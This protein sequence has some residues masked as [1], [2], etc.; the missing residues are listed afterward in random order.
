MVWCGLE[1]AASLPATVEVGRS[2]SV[3]WEPSPSPGI[4]GYR[5]HHGTRSREYSSVADVGLATNHV[6]RGLADGTLYYLAVTAYDTNF[7]SS[8]FS[9]EI[10]YLTAGQPVAPLQPEIIEQPSNQTVGTGSNATFRVG[11]Q[12]AGTLLFQWRKEGMD[13]TEGQ[14]F[15]GVQQPELRIQQAGGNEA[16]TYSVLVA[17]VLGATPSIDALLRVYVKP[18]LLNPVELPDGRTLLSIVNIDGSPVTAFQAYRHSIQARTNLTQGAWSYLELPMEIE[19]GVLVM[20]D[21]DSL[22]LPQRFFRAVQVEN[23]P[24]RLRLLAPAQL[25]D[26]GM[27]LY[28]RCE[29]EH[30]PLTPSEL[31][32]VTVEANTDLT[33]P[34]DW[35][36]VSAG[37]ECVGGLLVLDDHEARL[38]ASR[39]YR[40][41]MEPDPLAAVQLRGRVRET[42]GVFRL[43]LGREDGAPL[44]ITDAYNYE[45]VV[46]RDR[47]DPCGWTTLPGPLRL[48]NGMLQLV[49]PDTNHQLRFYQVYAR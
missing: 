9:D 40:A 23:S 30:G 20:E 29:S 21:P 24:K 26:G 7:A 22:V 4:S 42:D 33:S 14:H 10:F 11:A 39:F 8:D 15:Q 6:V 37:P 46:S 19:D 32:S 3:A 38:H 13:L 5:V 34:H 12:G 41:S 35:S 16:G 27:R 43:L 2:V 36:P 28:I 25:S 44:G 17:N 18:K 49:D 47:L 1:A 45:V 31:E 48:T